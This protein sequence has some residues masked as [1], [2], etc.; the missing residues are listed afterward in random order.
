MSIKNAGKLK[1]VYR[2]IA[3]E[4]AAWREEQART[5]NIPVR[6]ICS[7]LALA[8]L[9]HNPPKMPGDILDVRDIDLSVEDIKTLFVAVS[10]GRHLSETELR[11]PPKSNPREDAIKPLLGLALAYVAAKAKELDIDQSMLATRE[12]IFAFY[13]NDPGGLIANSWRCSLIGEQLKRLL[14]GETALAFDGQN[15]VV[16]EERSY[17]AVK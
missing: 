4:V 8:S 6:R 17:I 11:L 16:L 10:R 12:D 9:V 1:G 5:K 15:A 3:Q 7:D 13:Q 2:G 14:R